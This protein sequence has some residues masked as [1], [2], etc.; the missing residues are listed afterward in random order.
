MNKSRA[1]PRARNYYLQL[2]P[3]CTVQRLVKLVTPLKSWSSLSYSLDNCCVI[4][5]L[6]KPSDSV[7]VL[8]EPNLYT[9]DDFLDNILWSI[10]LQRNLPSF[11]TDRIFRSLQ[12]FLFFLL[13]L[14]TKKRIARNRK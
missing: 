13:C 6:M 2:F 5:Y 11:I 9:F 4:K 3:K 14:I 7:E 12:A 10:Y 8:S 1:L